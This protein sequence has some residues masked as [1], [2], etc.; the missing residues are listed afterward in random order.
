MVYS[1]LLVLVK[2]INSYNKNLH[3]YIPLDTLKNTNTKVSPYI[4][5]IRYNEDKV[6]SKEKNR[7]NFAKSEMNKIFENNTFSLISKYKLKESEEIEIPSIMLNNL[8]LLKR[9]ITENLNKKLQLQERL[10]TTNNNLIKNIDRKHIWKNEKIYTIKELGIN[11]NKYLS[12]IIYEYIRKN[13]DDSFKNES[14]YIIILEYNILFTNDECKLIKQK[15]E[16]AINILD[17]SIDYCNDSDSE[18]CK[19]HDELYDIISKNVEL[20]GDKASKN[21]K[22]FF[23]PS[24]SSSSSS[25]SKKSKKTSPSSSKKTA[26]SFSPLFSL[27]SSSSL[28]SS[29]EAGSSKNSSQSAPSTTTSKKSK[30][31]SPSLFSPLFSLFSSSSSSPQGEKSPPEA[32]S[33]KKSSST[34]TSTTS[35]TTS[36]KPSPLS[37]PPSPSLF[38]PLFSLFSSSSPQ[39]EKSPT[40]AKEEVLTEIPSSMTTTRSLKPSKNQKIQDLIE[41]SDYHINVYSNDSDYHDIWRD[42]FDLPKNWLGPRDENPDINCCQLKGSITRK[43]P[44][45]GNSSAFIE[46]AQDEKCNHEGWIELKGLGHELYYNKCNQNFKIERPDQIKTQEEK[47]EREE[48]DIEKNMELFK[49]EYQKNN[50]QQVLPYNGFFFEN[51]YNNFI[52]NYK[53]RDFGGG[54]DCL[55]HAIAGVL[56]LK[57]DLSGAYTLDHIF[58][59]NEIVKKMKEIYDNDDNSYPFVRKEMNSI[60]NID[61]YNEIFEELHEKYKSKTKIAPELKLLFQLSGGAIMLHMT[62]TMFK[63]SLPG[64]DDIMRQNP[65]LMQQF[66]QA[67]VNSM[68]QQNNG[69]GSFMND[70]NNSSSNTNYSNMQSQREEF[71]PPNPLASRPDIAMSR[72]PSKFDDAENMEQSFASV[73][74]TPAVSKTVSRTSTST[75]TSSRKDMTGPKDINDLL[76]GLKTKKI[77]VKQR[78]MMNDNESTISLDDMKELK[79]MKKPVRSK[80]PSSE[81]KKMNTVSLNI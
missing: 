2:N 60:E 9:D 20:V 73:D 17:N 24:A 64:M 43:N 78:E 66:T 32:G 13:S 35:P 33:S 39:G 28:S 50:I 8:F 25:S 37:S 36:K 65:E 21:V 45:D 38:S 48:R 76:S 72:G 67:A 6:N 75:T 14:V 34:T 26:P 27:F 5:Y 47:Q 58:V 54:G 31:P 23:N 81:K 10:N 16:N 53:I 74:R 12:D 80:R 15:I 62:N 68:S 56:N 55:F 4:H 61:D 69:F 46:K 18:I 11:K 44:W 52:T 1:N 7:A 51:T 57:Y 30:K 77:D 42:I 70:M 41:S 3:H 29:P 19:K 63:S 40:T 22:S 71:I 79:K 49:E 59:R